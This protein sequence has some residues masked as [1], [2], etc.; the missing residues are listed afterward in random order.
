MFSNFPAWWEGLGVLSKV[1]WIIA[2]PSTLIFIIQ[3]IMTF[4]GGDH[5]HDFDSGGD[6]HTELDDGSGFHFFT[7]KN[8]IAFFT[9][10][11]W[12]GLACVEG[13]FG[14][15]ISLLVSTLS[16]TIMMVIMAGLFYYISKFS[17]SGTLDFKNAIGHNGNVYIRIPAKKMGMGKIEI[18]VQGQLR[19]L[20]AMTE[21]IE[22]IKSGSLVEVIDIINENTLLVKRLR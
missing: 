14:L 20:N 19:T 3:L 5:D 22:I 15:F 10:F 6:S 12:T 2:F 8:M 21:D 9:L 18:E 7:F 17:Y 16:G 13:G 1:F 11:A 4:V